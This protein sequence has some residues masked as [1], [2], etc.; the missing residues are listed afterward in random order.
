MTS[1]DHFTPDDARTLD[2]V[3]Q[4]QYVDQAGEAAGGVEDL[5]A[6]LAQVR[7][8]MIDN[9]LGGFEDIPEVIGEFLEELADAILGLGGDG[10][11]GAIG[12]HISG[13]ASASDL[14]TLQDR[15]QALEGVIGYAHGY[16]NAGISLAIGP[17]KYGV[18]AQVGP[19]AGVVL[20]NGAFYLGSKGL[21]VADA[22]VTFDPAGFGVG[23]DTEVR[24]RVFD[25]GGTIYFEATNVNH[26]NQRQ[27]LTL[28]V[29]FTVPT[30]G[31]RV[32]LWVAAAVARNVQNGSF[33]NGISVEKRSTET[34]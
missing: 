8:T 10:L 16:C 25:P 11:Y 13:K 17:I 29:P 24:V 30:S 3:T 12:S 27:T 7:A 6:L 9:F 31:Y 19:I 33:F 28:H 22:R 1:P 18:D 2:T 20:T 26:G 34:S 5:Q 4:L 15:T 32:E 21:W 14:A 23:E